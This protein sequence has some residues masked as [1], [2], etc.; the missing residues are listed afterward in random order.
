MRTLAFAS[1]LAG[2]LCPGLAGP[3]LAVSPD[4]VISH[5]YGGGGNSGAT[6]RQDFIVIFNRGNASVS[7]AGM[8][9]QYA[10][11]TGTGNFGANDG[12]ITLLPSLM[13]APG[14]YFL[15]QEAQ[16]SG[17]TTDLPAPD[18]TDA[19][20]INM[21]ATG[22]KVA[23]ANTASSLGCNGG[24]TPCSP[25]QLAMIVDLVGYGGANFYEGAAPTGAP[26]NT[27]GVQRADEGCTDTDQNG[28]DFAVVAPVPRNTQSPLNP[29]GATQNTVST[30]GRV[31][32]FFR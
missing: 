9:L 5:V 10:S 20:P 29:C 2:G 15:V 16:G 17:G 18:L 28:N 31:K 22:G 27:T 12:Q 1:L 11:A 24:S 6:W 13:L 21:S 8:S 25:A 14:Q 3:T 23:L 26:S 4:L 7:L 30:W 19:T 32:G